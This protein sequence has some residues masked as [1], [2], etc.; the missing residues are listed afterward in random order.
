MDL[1]TNGI[2]ASGGHYA[3][4][5]HIH[6]SGSRNG[7]LVVGCVIG[8]GTDFWAVVPVVLRPADRHIER[9]PEIVDDEENADAHMEILAEEQQLR[10]DSRPLQV[11][12][13]ITFT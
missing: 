13:P 10:D 6:G 2:E 8:R 12:W 7:L 4:G 3:N 9:R 5:D 1:E 11:F